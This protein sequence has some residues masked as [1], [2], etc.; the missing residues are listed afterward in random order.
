MQQNTNQTP[1]EYKPVFVLTLVAEP[2]PDGIRDLRA[3][4]KLALRRFKLRCV[5][6]EQRPT[7]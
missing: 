5:S 6:I 3:L 1:T 4:L 7:P 2:G